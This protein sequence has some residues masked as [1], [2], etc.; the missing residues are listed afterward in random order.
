MARNAWERVI[1]ADLPGKG[2]PVHT[3]RERTIQWE[4]PLAHLPQTMTMTGL[5]YLQAIGT[6][7]MPHPPIMALLGIDGLSAE[8]GRVE[9]TCTAAEYHYNPIG[10]VH[11]GVLAT[12]LD[13]AMS[14]AVHSTL[15][16]GVGYTTL[17]VKVNFVRG[18]TLASGRMR[19]FGE[20]IHVGR[21]VATAQG[22]LTDGEGRLLAHGTTTCLIMRQT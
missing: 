11:G 7:D 1:L 20:T 18:A 19:A 22:R 3:A 14:C 6:G 13:S 15:E 9:F 5:E 2:E 12:L 17:E 10:L 4:D 16:A 21:T 8:A